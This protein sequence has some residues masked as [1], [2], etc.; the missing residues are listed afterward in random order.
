MAKAP[1]TQS[2][3]RAIKPADRAA[4]ATLL[5]GLDAPQVKPPLAERRA[6]DFYATGEPEA[7]RA[8]LA[9]DGAR[10]KDLGHA[11]EPAA[12]AGD[13]T[14]ELVRFGLTCRSSD[15]IDR[16]CPD[17]ELRSYYDCHTSPA[18]I[19]ITNP[20][21]NEIS[22]GHGHGRWLRHALAM[23]CWEYMALLLAGDGRL[24]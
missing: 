19:I 5:P 11:W 24:P 18:P 13:I 12:G 9:R 7:I 23:P 2:L 8:L 1:S 15:I 16:G 6:D 14:R 4:P 21:Y 22:A 10:L 3:F 17:V 20:P